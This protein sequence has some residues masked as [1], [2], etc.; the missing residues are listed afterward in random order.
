MKGEGVLN[1]INRV[2]KIAERVKGEYKGTAK[3]WRE[4]RR[5]EET[6]VGSW[7]A[8]VSVEVSGNWTR[9]C[10]YI[11]RPA[12]PKSNYKMLKDHSMKLVSLTLFHPFFSSLCGSSFQSVFLFTSVFSRFAQKNKS[13]MFLYSPIV[14]LHE[15]ISQDP[16]SFFLCNGCPEKGGWAYQGGARGGGGGS[17]VF[18]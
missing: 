3:A 6:V 12:H 9:L 17:K 4:L 14:P 7:K 5:R 10:A 8:V 18:V 13:C 16:L 15:S 1:Y 11:Q 2:W